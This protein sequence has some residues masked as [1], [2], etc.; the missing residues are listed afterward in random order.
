MD[1]VFCSDC[2]RRAGPETGGHAYKCGVCNGKLI[3]ARSPCLGAPASGNIHASY[4]A[5]K[6]TR[7]AS[8]GFMNHLA[9]GVHIIKT[10]LARSLSQCV[11]P[12]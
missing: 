7:P 10:R 1:A 6:I 11:G 4:V 12:A 9:R 2:G 8:T 3:I 5:G